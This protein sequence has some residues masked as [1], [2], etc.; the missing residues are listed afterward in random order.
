MSCQAAIGTKDPVQKTEWPQ[1]TADRT[2][3]SHGILVHVDF[4]AP[5][6]EAVLERHCEFANT[7]GVHDFSYG[8]YLVEPDFHRGFALLEEYNSVSSMNAE[9]PDMGKVRALA[10]KFLNII[11]VID[12]AGFPKERSDEY[13][14]SWERRLIVAS[15]AENVQIKISSLGMCD[16]NWIVDSVRLYVLHCIETFDPERSLFATNWP[17]DSLEH[18]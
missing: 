9:W 2:G 8:G 16:N 4:R 6:V 13:F 3:F 11:I 18:I 15:K 17:I 7:R 10:A 5:G 14:Q 12:H 1:E